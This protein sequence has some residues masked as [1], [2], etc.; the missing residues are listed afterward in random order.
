MLNNEY[1]PE[2]IRCH[3]DEKTRESSR[4][5]INKKFE[6]YVN[7]L[8][9][10]KFDTI[11]YLAIEIDNLCNFEC[12]T[13]NSFLSTKL[14]KR[15]RFLGYGVG[16]NNKAD[17]SFLNVLDLSNLRRLHLHG[18]EPFLTPNLKEI[19][20]II[21]DQIDPKW[22]ELVF[23]TNGST[24]PSDD[25]LEK[26]KKIDVV[27]I[28]ISLESTHKINDYIRYRGSKDQVIE[29]AGILR[30]K[31]PNAVID[32]SSTIS[33]Y[34]ADYMPKTKREIEEL[35]YDHYW[36]FASNT[37]SMLDYAPDEYKEWLYSRV[38]DTEFEIA[39]KNYYEDKKYDKQKWDQFI[40]ECKQLDEYYGIKL[41][42]YHHN[43]ND[44]IDKYI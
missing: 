41:S 4:Q 11:R 38:K 24:I 28:S 27:N 34:N 10:N 37:P 17:I 6:Q 44:L 29:N 2:C 31:L 35:G 32:F 20:E 22:L 43:L 1:T 23:S 42:D 13:C 19:L 18:G 36:Y 25:I 8:S 9:E 3:N 5:K 33:L 26:L 7:I 39:Y 12:R 30:E 14:Q 40:K 15:D 16:K 21:E